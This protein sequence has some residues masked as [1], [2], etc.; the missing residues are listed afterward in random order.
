LAG[1]VIAILHKAPQFFPPSTPFYT[2]MP[3]ESRWSDSTLTNSSL[4]TPHRS[5]G[6]VHWASKL[7]RGLSAGLPK[8][9]ASS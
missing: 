9:T 3:G 7:Q 1:P 5:I 8:K 6:A 2:N 4:E